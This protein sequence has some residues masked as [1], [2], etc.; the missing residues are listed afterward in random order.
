MITAG[1]R[2]TERFRRASFEEML[3][4]PEELVKRLKTKQFFESP[5]GQ[6]FYT[7]ARAIARAYEQADGDLADLERGAD[8]ELETQKQMAGDDIL[9]L[10]NLEDS[11][12]ASVKYCCTLDF[13]HNAFVNLKK[14][15]SRLV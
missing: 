4:N 15:S 9:S 1:T 14:L 6:A 5:E 11:F 8:T 13:P 7:T 10:F 12:P 2:T 3:L